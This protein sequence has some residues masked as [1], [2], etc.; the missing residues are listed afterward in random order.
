MATVVLEDLLEKGRYEEAT[1]VAD[2]LIAQHLA[3]AYAIVK[4]G[5]AYYNLIRTEYLE[6][7][8]N[9]NAVPHALRSRYMHL[10]RQ[11]AAAFQTAEAMGWRQ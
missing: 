4:K 8:P 1:A 10:S 5:S 2:L 3:Y 9:P 7:Y 11:N 6:R